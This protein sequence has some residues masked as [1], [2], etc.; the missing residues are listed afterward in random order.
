[1]PSAMSVT[2]SLAEREAERGRAGIED[3]DLE[4]P[5]GD[6]TGLP[7]ELVEPWLHDNAVPVGVDVETV[8][9]ARRGSVETHAELRRTGRGRHEDQME[10]ARVEAVR[11]APVR[12]VAHRFFPADG[13]APLERP[14]VDAEARWQRVRT[15][16]VIRDF[17]RRR[18]ALTARVAHVRFR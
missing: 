9:V 1:V 12:R 13:P 17:F 14:L 10:I 5:V 8:R 16:L 4:Q 15:R 18:E 6:G 3:L 2:S 7:D 11:D